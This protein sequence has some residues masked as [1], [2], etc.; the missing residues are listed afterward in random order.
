MR[1]IY[2]LQRSAPTCRR[3]KITMQ[4]DSVQRVEEPREALVDVYRCEACGRM[5]AVAV[6]VERV[7]A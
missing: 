5:E 3:C 6:Q 7:V 2:D 1:I 4:W